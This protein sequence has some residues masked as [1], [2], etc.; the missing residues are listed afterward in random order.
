MPNMWI[1]YL[2]TLF[3]VFKGTSTLFSIMNVAIYILTNSVG[4]FSL[5]TRPSICYLW[6]FLMMWDDTLL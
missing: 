1:K 3:L 5:N 4:V 2:V 6:T